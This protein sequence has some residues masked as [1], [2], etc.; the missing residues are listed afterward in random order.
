MDKQPVSFAPEELADDTIEADEADDT[1][2]WIP[3][4]EAAINSVPN[5][6]DWAL[7]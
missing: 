1:W 4:D 7:V 2:E 5:E 3:P 6:P